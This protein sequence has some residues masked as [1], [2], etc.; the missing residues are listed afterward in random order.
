MLPIPN[1]CCK[2][3]QGL[4]HGSIPSIISKHLVV[5]VSIF[6]G[7]VVL[8][9]LELVFLFLFPLSIFVFIWFA[10]VRYDEDGKFKGS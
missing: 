5:V 9:V 2:V 8:S 7:G 10:Y 4:L 6:V 3:D 1:S